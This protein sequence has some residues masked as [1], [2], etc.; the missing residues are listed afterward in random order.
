MRIPVAPRRET[1]QDLP[2]LRA[3]GRITIA[4]IPTAV[5]VGGPTRGRDSV[6][7][8]HGNPGPMD[9]W[10][11]IVEAVSPT[12]RVIAMDLPAF[13]RTARPRNF[14]YSIGGYAAFLGA[15]LRELEVD[16]RVHLVAHDLGG[17]WAVAWAR[18][19]PS[20]VASFTLIATPLLPSFRWHAWA[21]I[22]QTPIVGELLQVLAMRST[23]GAV[24][25]RGNPRPLPSAFVDRVTG[26]AD[27]A[28]KLRILPL[29]R[30]VRDP[31]AAFGPLADALR[32]FAVPGCVV[33]GSDDPY[34]DPGN[35]APTAALFSSS[36]LHVIER[37]GHWPFVDEPARVATIVASFLARH[38]A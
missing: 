1:S 26:Y 27:L 16:D 32:S 34:A 2:T 25:R 17:A 12:M 10:D 35:A 7:F 28:Q 9:D 15:A 13:G 33:W 22:W 6:V 24:M 4:G 5:H 18:Q 19:H 8:V 3:T 30:S 14:D 29:Y 20:R 36:E 31:H 21:R 38:A 23:I 37:A 11:P